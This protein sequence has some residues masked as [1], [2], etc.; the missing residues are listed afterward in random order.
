MEI[1]MSELTAQQIIELH[2][3]IIERTG[4]TKGVLNIGSIDHL[5]YRLSREKDAFRKAS[6]VLEKIITTHPFFDGN[7][8][9]GFQ[10]AD[11]ILGDNGYYIA[12][13]K[14]EILHALLKIAKYQ[15]NIKKIE[16]WIKRKAEKSHF[17]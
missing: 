1:Q 4:G 6:I 8:R 17:G 13:S 2:D 12:A 7:K 10:V 15:C 9:T 5:I 3:N 16:E 14:Q 11:L